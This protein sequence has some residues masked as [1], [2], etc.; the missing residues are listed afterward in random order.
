MDDALIYARTVSKLPSLITSI[1]SHPHPMPS[2]LTLLARGRMCHPST[3]PSTMRCGW[4]YVGK[5]PAA[6]LW[7]CQVWMVKTN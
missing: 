7:V 6:W 3:H 5:S 4:M 1:P 2:Y